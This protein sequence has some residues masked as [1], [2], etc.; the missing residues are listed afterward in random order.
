LLEEG[1]NFVL[2]GHIHAQEISMRE[3][4]AGSIYDIATS[5]FAVYPHQIG[6]LTLVPAA[7]AVPEQPGPSGPESPRAVLWRYGVKPL[8][9]EAWARNSESG[10]IRFLNFSQW[11]KEFFIRSS[12]DMG[13]E[14]PPLNPEDRA[15]LNSLMGLLN[16][17]YF[18]GTRGLNTPDLKE[19]PGYT[20]LR[21]YAAELGFLAAYAATIMAPSPPGDTELEI[22][23]PIAD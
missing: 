8:E 1:V 14:Y 2:S 15:A 20:V 10:D 12:E 3:R 9:V 11:S 23:P 21:E 16:V 7:P 17:R 4:E 22:P 6:T 5:A 13:R 19:S 18:S